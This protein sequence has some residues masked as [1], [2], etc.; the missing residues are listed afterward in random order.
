M[1]AMEERAAWL[2]ENEALI[3]WAAHRYA[4][5]GEVED[6]AAHLRLSVLETGSYGYHQLR[7]AAQEWHRMTHVVA[8]PFMHHE[9]REACAEKPAERAVPL[10][11]T[12][13]GE[14]VQRPE[15][16][17][18]GFEDLAIT[19][20]DLAALPWHEL[21]EQQRE[22]IRLKLIDGLTWPQVGNA[23]GLSPS[24]AQWHYDRGLAILRGES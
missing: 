10:T 14:Q 22:V 6:L 18:D 21:N 12:I 19:R 16:S 11:I 5:G 24:G 7:T 15:L 2:A 3:Q 9:W 23:M 13:D 1:K 17:V 20:A 4:R 8:R